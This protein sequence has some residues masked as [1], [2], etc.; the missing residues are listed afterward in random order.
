[1]KHYLESLIKVINEDDWQKLNALELKTSKLK[2]FLHILLDNRLNEIPSNAE[3][4]AKLNIDDKLHRKMKSVLLTK[5]Y[6]ALVPEGGIKLLELLSRYRLHD[7][8]IRELVKQEK[9]IRR[10][11]KKEKQKFYF[12]AFH[13]FRRLPVSLVT[14]DHYRDYGNKLLE[15]VDSKDLP[16]RTLILQI[17][18]FSVKV[19]QFYFNMVETEA[20]KEELEE[21]EESV[22]SIKSV[23]LQVLLSLAKGMFYYYAERD[24][25]KSLNT[26]LNAKKLLSKNDTNVTYD[27]SCMIEII[28]GLNY[29]QMNKFQEALDVLL[30]A[31]T[32]YPAMMKTQTHVIS[33]IVSLQMILG[34]MKEA[35]LLLNNLI[36]RFLNI[37]E[38]ESSEI[39]SISYIKYYLLNDDLNNAYAYLSKA[40]EF[41]N[42]K[43]FSTHDIEVR[44]LEIIYFV[45]SEDYVFAESLI[46]RGVK[47]LHEK[48]KEKEVDSALQRFKLLKQICRTSNENQSELSRFPDEITKSFKGYDY[49]TGVLIQKGCN[50]RV[51]SK[52]PEIKAHN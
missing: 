12:Y 39:V 23:T 52:V 2:D 3:I 9:S 17:R 41:L 15:T 22:G 19:L 10:K 16:E 30:E 26:L 42:K 46:N 6:E 1:M 47:Y 31:K 29:Y 25:G 18:I 45:Y 4:Q 21:L 36:K 13:G 28:I 38:A 32:N 5:C 14:V 49:L 48:A 27:E 24:Y 51:K 50:A 40:R 37:L 35:K 33:H 20:L 44:T 7:H 8:F 11:S 34:N 43:F